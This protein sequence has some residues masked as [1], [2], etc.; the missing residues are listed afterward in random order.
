MTIYIGIRPND[1]AYNRLYWS[2]AS[3]D[4]I[5]PHFFGTTF[6]GTL[7]EFIAQV[8]DD[9]GNGFNW[10][11]SLGMPPDF[12]LPY[13]QLGLH[14]IQYR[15]DVPKGLIHFILVKCWAATFRDPVAVAGVR[16]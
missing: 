13:Q 9:M 7:Q 12:N 15:T 2:T 16:D 8:G 11:G 1:T 3:K 4:V 5:E 10:I 6:M 14:P